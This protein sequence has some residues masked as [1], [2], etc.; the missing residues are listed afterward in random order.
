MPEETAIPEEVRFDPTPI[1]GIDMGNDTRTFFREELKKRGFSDGMT[2][3]PLVFAEIQAMN[4]ERRFELFENRRKKRE[5]IQEKAKRDRLVMKLK[6]W[7]PVGG[8][9]ASL[10]GFGGYTV[11][12]PDPNEVKPADVKEDVRT[13]DKRIKDNA[14]ATKVNAENIKTV[15][16]LLVEQQELTVE[17]VDYIGLKIDAAHPRTRDETAKPPSL[18]DAEKEVQERKREAQ[19]GK[20]LK[21]LPDPSQ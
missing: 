1:H 5:E 7:I 19:A 3:D 8:I 17:S 9:F 21:S 6:I 18:R 15:A 12:K 20:L 2:I 10:L 11:A 14:E 16:E 13:V 4:E